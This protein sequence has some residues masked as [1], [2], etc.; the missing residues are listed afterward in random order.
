MVASLE[1]MVIQAVHHSLFH[2]PEN[3]TSLLLTKSSEK[4]KLSLESLKDIPVASLF[5]VLID[6]D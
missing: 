1:G 2:R 6:R 3:I 4:V 5:G